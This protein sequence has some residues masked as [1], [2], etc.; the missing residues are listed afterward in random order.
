MRSPGGEAVGLLGQLAAALWRIPAV[1]VVKRIH[2]GAL[3]CSWKKRLFQVSETVC[4]WRVLSLPEFPLAFKLMSIGLMCMPSQI[5]YVIS[6]SF[7]TSRQRFNPIFPLHA[8]ISRTPLLTRFPLQR[9]LSF[10]D[11]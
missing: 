11:S 8:T 5:C 9:S 2:G 1:D 4:E 3:G 10:V 7:M 6:T